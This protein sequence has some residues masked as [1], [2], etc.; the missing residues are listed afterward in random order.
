MTQLQS[1]R[2]AYTP[3]GVPDRYDRGFLAQEFGNIKR[4]LTPLGVRTVMAST[5]ALTTDSVILCDPTSAAITVT[6][7]APN[8]ALNQV[9]TIKQITSNAHAVTIGGTVDGSA[10]PTLGGTNK[11]VTL[12][13]DGAAWWKIGEV[14]LAFDL[15]RQTSPMIRTA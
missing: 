3:R 15:L 13:S 8:R 6:L 12:V 1:A 10:N 14:A 4:A 2:Q 11:S 7:Y 5:Q 9:V